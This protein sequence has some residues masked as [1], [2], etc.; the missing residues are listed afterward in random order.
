MKVKL[1]ELR[2]RATNISVAAIKMT[3]VPGHERSILWHSGFHP[4]DFVFLWDLSKGKI[5]YDPYSWGTGSRTMTA[6]HKWIEKNF[7]NIKSG[8]LV[9]V[10]VILGEKTEPSKSE[11]DG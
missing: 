3:P 11:Y 6:A 5:E 7:D 4:G 9:D 1:I 2:D 8:D 10:E